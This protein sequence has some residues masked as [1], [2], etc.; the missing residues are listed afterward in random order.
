[1]MKTKLT[2]VVGTVAFVAA[3]HPG[4][5]QTREATTKE[6]L[7][8]AQSQSGKRAVEDLI[9]KLRGARQGGAA[10]PS[11]AGAAAATPAPGPQVATPPSQTPSSQTPAA[12]P[13]PMLAAPAVAAPPPGAAPQPAAGPAVPAAVAT[14]A[15]PPASAPGS[16]AGAR[17]ATEAAPATP[18]TAV[19]APRTPGPAVRAISQPSVP[20]VDET[21]QTPTLTRGADDPQTPPP[22][23]DA[24]PVQSV[25]GS[26]PVVVRPTVKSIISRPFASDT[27]M[28]KAPETAEKLNLPRAD[29]EVLFD[30]DSAAVTALAKV[31]LDQ[32]GAAL[33]DPRLAGQKFVVAGHTD[34][35][36]PDG[37][38]VV[39][40]QRRAE[41]VRQYM[42]DTFKLDPA[43]LIAR[44][45]GKSQLKNKRNPFA[46]ENRRVQIINWTSQTAGEGGN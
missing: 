2:L 40:S 7:G 29:V 21:T 11:A 33:T 1:M 14:P 43:N 22:A 5:A 42:I 17:P 39:L 6:L 27:E 4:F 13:A 41:A 9:D 44:G 32:L 38:N 30:L 24:A 25:S 23:P 35:Y 26:P 18:A 37:Y 8:R 36:G 46:K 34:G 12:A 19:V 15:P 28:A 3:T 16:D 31:S 10:A 45:F 20:A